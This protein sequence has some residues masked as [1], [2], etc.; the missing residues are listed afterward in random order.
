MPKGGAR[1][2]AGR[3][4]KPL[5]EKVLEGNPGGR[6]LTVLEFKAPALD[7]PAPPDYL[8]DLAAGEGS[9]PSATAIYE[10]TVEWLKSTGCLHLIYPGHVEEYALLKSR[11][12]SCEAKNRAGLLSAHPTTGSAIVSPY[13]RAG[14]DFLRAADTVWSRIWQVVTQNAEKSYSSTPHDDLMERLLS[15]RR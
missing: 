13:V 6:P 4:K 3:P 12:L 10:S 2:G 5:A 9:C 7:V 1:P 8:D 14:L 11:W 15:A